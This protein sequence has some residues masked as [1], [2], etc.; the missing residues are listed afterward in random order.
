MWFYPFIGAKFC[1]PFLQG[2]KSTCLLAPLRWKFSLI[3]KKWSENK[4][5]NDIEVFQKYVD[6]TL[7]RN[8]TCVAWILPKA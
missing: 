5:C 7:G 1:G 6:I 4:T 3:F 8:I 2:Y